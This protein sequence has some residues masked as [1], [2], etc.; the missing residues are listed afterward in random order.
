MNEK[1]TPFT[2]FLRS[3]K[4]LGYPFQ[5]QGNDS[6]VLYNRPLC[7]RSKGQGCTCQQRS[8]QW[9]NLS[10]FAAVLL[11]RW[12]CHFFVTCV[13]SL[14]LASRFKNSQNPSWFLNLFW[15]LLITR[16]HKKVFITDPVI[17][18]IKNQHSST[19]ILTK[20]KLVHILSENM[21]LLV[22]EFFS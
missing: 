7:C 17:Y 6:Q 21:T 10:I 14:F 2:P 19:W 4:K 11:P 15:G 12:L 9:P 18:H 22:R 20:P 8:A 5:Q 3:S 1:A 16:G 13:S